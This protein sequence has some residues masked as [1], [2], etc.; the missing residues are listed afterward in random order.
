[1]TVL[2]EAHPETQ[3]A[4][5]GGPVLRPRRDRSYPLSCRRLLVAL[6]ILLLST[7][8]LLASGAYLPWIGPLAGIMCV[9][10]IPTVLLYLANIGQA[11]ARS[12]RL[13]NS[14][15]LTVLLLMVSGLAANTVLPHLGVSGALA[16]F[17]VV[18][19][20]DGLCLAL[21]TWVY[22]RRPRI[23]HIRL[24]RLTWRDDTVLSLAGLVVALAVMGAVRLNNGAG[25]GLTLFMLGVVVGLL[26]LLLAWR[27]RLHPGVIPTVIYAVSLALLLMTSL[28]GW[29][30]TGHDVQRE[31]RVFELVKSHSNWKMSRF[32]DAYNACLSITILPTMLWHWTRV[33]DPYVFKVFFQFLFAFCPVL[34]YR[35]GTRV[36][37]RTVALLA[38]IYFISFVTFFQD[39]PMLNRQEIAFLFLA[40]GLLVVFNDRLAIRPR[41][42]LF[43]VF[44]LGIVL[45]HYSTTYV[46]IG[47]L[48]VAWALRTGLRPAGKIL[49]RIAAPGRTHVLGIGTIGAVVVASALWTIPVTH[50]ETGLS[51][52]VTSAINSLLGKSASAKSSDTSYSIFSLHKVSPAQRLAEYKQSSLEASQRAPRD[53]Y[54]Q[55]TLSKYSTPP[56]PSP[57]LP[58]TSLGRALTGLGVNVA[59]FNSAV[60]QA[61]A[62]L[63]QL[64]IGL[65]LIATL[66]ARRPRIRAHPEFYCLAGAN[67]FV[68][69]LQVILP[70]ISV[71]YG[72]LRA[73]QQSLL[74]LD[75]FLVAGSL[76]LVPRLGECRKVLL[77]SVLAVTFFASSTGMI[78]QALGGYDPQ[79]H[80]NNS[81]TYYNIYYLHP[82]EVVGIDW[83]VQHRP[84]GSAGAV[85]SEIQ[86][87]R[88]TFTRVQTLAPLN[89]LNDMYP[90][91]VRKNSYVF[92]GYANVHNGQSTVPVNGDLVTYQYPVN[93]LDDNK[94]LIYSNG[95]ARVYR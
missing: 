80:V 60:R 1:M 90:G 44:G 83:L 62:K 85:Q 95:G 24:P 14:V 9:L 38:T 68:V 82:E 7:N 19:T 52:T 13:G 77:A 69:L 40:A 35:L 54:D 17:P 21:G 33:S 3:P 75:V 78:T 5:K 36:A 76:A 58:L 63:L 46:T 10:G 87:D 12:E 31:Y 94:D 22:R 16:P 39:M 53:Y 65:G 89:T 15:I 79:L 93:F 2:I 64:L 47:V 42:R 81:G 29:Y 59:S 70:A 34:V 55:T 18:A 25:G 4:P 67:L 8:A 37:S 23:V 26:V 43:V 20:V 32:Q 11:P 57:Q 30:T 73:F 72:V 84:S 41:Q 91:L 45:S 27:D 28:R 50:T 61:S 92:L 48:M 88:Y 71:D 66:L 6:G 86:T 49:G 74:I 56:V 51:H